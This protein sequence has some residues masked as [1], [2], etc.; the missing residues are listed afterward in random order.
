M[1]TL[2]DIEIA[3]YGESQSRSKQDLI[4]RGVCTDS[5]SVSAGD[6]FFCIE[7]DNFDGHAF[8]R[9]AVSNGAAVVVAA[10]FMPEI[11]DRPV[12]MVPDTTVA[13]GMLAAFHRSRTQAQVVAVTGSSG[14]TTVKELLAGMVAVDKRV[15]KNAGNLNNQIGLPQS[16][17]RADPM[18]D[19]WVL[20]LGI[21]KPHDMDE[22]GRIATPDMAVIHNIGPAHLEGL[23]DLAGVARAKASLLRYLSPIGTAMV[24]KDYELLWREAVTIRPDAVAFSTRDQSCDF[25]CALLETTPQGKGRFHLKTPAMEADMVLPVCGAHHAENLAAAAAVAHHL[26]L[27]AQ[28]LLRGAT[29]MRTMKQR[30]VCHQTGKVTLIDD[31]YNANPKSMAS[32]M[33]TAH[34]MA[35]G[36]PLVLVLGDMKELGEHAVAAHEELGR[37]AR[38]LAPL[39]L[40]FKG[41]HACDVARGYG[42]NGTELIEI[43]TPAETA[44]RVSNLQLES[45]VVLV[46]G[47]RSCRMEEHAQILTRKLAQQNPDEDTNT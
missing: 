9:Q 30:F 44:C 25:H 38:K 46:K 39:A 29:D 18:A 41:E 14:K 19:V 4:I 1:F 27:S 2:R 32:S 11:D 43:R 47:S 35:A 33:Q 8:A 42:R 21:S 24:N 31:T 45:G 28:A 23:G 40:L 26:C 22:L 5:R 36:M 34:D 6:I 13:L 17:F 7:G 16:I 37:E 15:S 12:L 10:R 20:E 3:L